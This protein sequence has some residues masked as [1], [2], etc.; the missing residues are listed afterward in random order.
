MRRILLV[1]CCAAIFA[2]ST[3]V[4]ASGGGTSIGPLFNSRNQ[5]QICMVQCKTWCHFGCDINTC[6]FKIKIK[7]PNGQVLKEKMF[8][9]VP[10]DGLRKLAYQGIENPISCEITTN[11]WG[12]L[13]VEPVWC[14]LDNRAEVVS[15]MTNE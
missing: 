3:A 13:A 9:N 11:D 5:Q 14:V 2:G 7:G 1:L 15:C 4:F 10:D 6:E 12:D 8:R